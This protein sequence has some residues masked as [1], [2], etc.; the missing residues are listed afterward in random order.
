MIVS[1]TDAEARV[2]AEAVRRELRTAGLIGT[3]EQT[4][5]RLENLNWTE[6]QNKDAVNYTP[7]QIVEFH[8]ITKAVAT[9][10]KREPKFLSGEQWRVKR[11]EGN[12]VIIERNGAERQL[13][14]SQA[15]N[16]STHSIGTLTLSL[17]DR[18]R[19]TK[20]F[21]VR[22]LETK[23]RCRNNDVHTVT[24]IDQDGIRLSNGVS[25][26]K[27][28]WHLDQGVVVTSHA[29][30]GKTVDQV[31]LSVPIRTFS[32]VNEAQW[33]VSLS[34]TR[35]AMQVLI[36]S[37]GALKEAVLRRGTRISAHELVGEIRP[38]PQRDFISLEANRGH[39]SPLNAGPVRERPIQNEATHRSR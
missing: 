23:H 3:K 17:G 6:A 33:Y 11:R 28:L 2:V 4:F 30:Q 1:P 10:Q 37:L 27:G 21:V 38:L 12:S 5:E 35:S 22:D 25:L 26:R 15:K 13:P 32:Q 31:L 16:F 18:V 9:G 36:D 24:A 20:N 14:L 29:A 34:R 7:G 19:M 39:E 8:R